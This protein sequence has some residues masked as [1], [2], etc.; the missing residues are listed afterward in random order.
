[1]TSTAT[2]RLEE[3]VAESPTLTSPKA[4]TVYYDYANLLERAGDLEKARAMFERIVEEDAAYK[5]VLDRL[6]KLSS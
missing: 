4:K 6:S 3:A 1:M 2:K 5:D